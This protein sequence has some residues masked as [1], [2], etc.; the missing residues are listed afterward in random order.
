MTTCQYDSPGGLPVPKGNWLAVLYTIMR[1]VP[2]FV[3][4]THSDEYHDGMNTHNLIEWL[5][6]QPIQPNLP[7]YSASMQNMIIMLTSTKFKVG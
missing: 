6:K 4:N 3:G 7:S 2:I 1:Y 5:E